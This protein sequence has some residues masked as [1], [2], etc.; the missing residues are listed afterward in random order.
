MRDILTKDIK[1][2][3]LKWIDRWLNPN[4][5]NKIIGAL[6]FGGFTLI[7]YQNLMS[8]LFSID[9]IAESVHIKLSVQNDNDNLLKI[10]GITTVFIGSF[11][12]YLVHIVHKNNITFSTLKEASCQIKKF[13]D[14]N[15]RIFKTYGPNS[16]SH[17]ITDLNTEQELQIWNKSKLE[18]II[19]NN[20]RIYTILENIKFFQP[21]EL[22]LVTAMKNHI[23]AFK[24][25][26]NNVDVDYTKY[27]F[28]IK[29]ST[30]ISKYC[31]RVGLK[32]KTLKL[33]SNWI[34]EHIASNMINVEEKYFFGSI[35]YDKNPMDL[36]ILLL[37]NSDRYDDILESSNKLRHMEQNFE[38]RFNL[39]LHLTVFFTK[40][41]DEFNRFKNELL[42][43]KEL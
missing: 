40:E 3:F 7:F 42:D 5:H 15:K 35:L 24:E 12:Y 8:S 10:F 14:D 43:T 17:N 29:F 28:P 21:D 27:Q 37:V 2:I 13:L 30:L 16:S 38:K 34:I 31:N 25:H 1:N 33:Y 6:I 22:K 9:W 36:D 39:K 11:F 4:F 26:C 41:I 20:E 32:E 19:P 18:H 23:E